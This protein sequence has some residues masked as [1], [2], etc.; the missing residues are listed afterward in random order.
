MS[1]NQD[2]RPRAFPEYIHPSYY[3]GKIFF[4]KPVTQMTS[5]RAELGFRQNLKATQHEKALA[6]NLKD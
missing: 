2:I 4:S 1:V 5:T 6:K 3:P